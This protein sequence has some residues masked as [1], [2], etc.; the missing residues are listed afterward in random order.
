VFFAWFFSEW[1]KWSTVVVGIF[2]VLLC[3][4][5]VVLG[6]HFP[7]DI[8]IGSLIGSAG[9]MLIIRFVLPFVELKMNKATFFHSRGSFYVALGLALIVIIVQYLNLYFRLQ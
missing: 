3:F 1:K 9:A 6:V 2:S 4:T 5:R 8:F 7:G